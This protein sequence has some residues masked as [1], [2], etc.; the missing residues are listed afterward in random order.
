MRRGEEGTRV[1]CARRA[2]SA[3]IVAVGVAAKNGL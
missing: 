2:F 3:G 1:R